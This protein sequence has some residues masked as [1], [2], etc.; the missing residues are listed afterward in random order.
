V[1]GFIVHVGWEVTRELIHHLMDGVD[2]QVI[3]AAEQAALALPHVGHAHVRARWMGRSLLVE[4]EGFVA[5]GMSIAEGE[6][7]GR[8]VED[9]VAGA[10]P[11]CRAVLWSPRS[12]PAP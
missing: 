12:I 7:I 4:V 5:A 6:A 1:T 9:A 10:V 2:P 8:Q 3:A 11:G